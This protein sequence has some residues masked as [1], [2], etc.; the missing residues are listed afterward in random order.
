MLFVK[1][2]PKT[3]LLHKQKWNSS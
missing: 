3:K 2:F 1:G